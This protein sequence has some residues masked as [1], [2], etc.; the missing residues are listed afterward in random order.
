MADLPPL[1]ACRLCGSEVDPTGPHTYR[2]VSGW[3]Q[4]RKPNA[5]A[6]ITGEVGFACFE[7]VETAKYTPADVGQ[8]EL[9]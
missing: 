4:N 3:V 6:L 5:V 8:G 9:F 2:R 1:F 7:C